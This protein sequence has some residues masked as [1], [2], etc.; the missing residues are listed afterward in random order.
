MTILLPSHLRENPTASRGRW[1]PFWVGAQAQVPL[2]GAVG[3][4]RAGR[5]WEGQNPSSLTEECSGAS[6]RPEVTFPPGKGLCPRAP[7][8]LVLA[9]YPPH[10]QSAGTLSAPGTSVARDLASALDAVRLLDDSSGPGSRGLVKGGVG[11]QP[12]CPLR[13]SSA[14]SGPLAGRGSYSDVLDPSAGWSITAAI[15]R[16]LPG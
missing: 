6:S 4:S 12:L 13:L 16:R 1:R 14:T 10:F 8:P 5:V 11:P 7:R 9:P 15:P 3:G 2:P